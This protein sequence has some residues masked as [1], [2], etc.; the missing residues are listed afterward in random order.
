MTGPQWQQAWADALDRLEADVV[1]AE[2]LLAEEHR[3]RDLPLTD[4]WR[5]PAG[6]GP[7]PID[8]RPR[9]DDVL[10]RQ[11]AVAQGLA[12]RL[13]GTVRHAAM[14]DRIDDRPAPRPSYVDTA[15]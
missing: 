1:A 14:L 10:R 6:L 13:A 5:P 9:A 12:T 11:L 2:Q 15:M 4:P 3:M 8:L 7:L